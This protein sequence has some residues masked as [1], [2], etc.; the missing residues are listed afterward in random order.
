MF[1]T[2]VNDTDDKFIKIGKILQDER[3]SLI[4]RGRITAL[5]VLGWG[6]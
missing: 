4:G 5:H 1:I 6:G 3:T 2:G